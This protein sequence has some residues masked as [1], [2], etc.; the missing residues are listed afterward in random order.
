MGFG[1]DCTSGLSKGL[2]ISLGILGVWSEF[3]ILIKSIKMFPTLPR[4]VLLGASMNSLDC[5]AV[6]EGGFSS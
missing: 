3:P 1:G 4:V 2:L 6:T 5:K